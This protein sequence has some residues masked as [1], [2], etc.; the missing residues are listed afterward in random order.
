MAEDPGESRIPIVEERARIEKQLVPTGRVSIS[1]KVEERLEVLR[2]ELVA[3]TV[4]VERVT[5]NREVD[6]PP[7]VRSEG[8]VLII[9]VIEQRLVVEKR[10][11]VTEELH[12][13]RR[14]RV[15][16]VEIPV[17]LRSTRVSVER[18]EAAR[19]RDPGSD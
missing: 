4:S 13:R 1:S 14:E 19:P 18:A 5:V 16:A 9:P 15:E 10:W 7:D 11:V 6:V 3:Q 2:E 12:V 17:E 8:D